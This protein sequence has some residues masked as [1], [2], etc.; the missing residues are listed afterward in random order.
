[1]TGSENESSAAGLEY[2]EAQRDLVQTRAKWAARL[3]KIFGGARPVRS[4]VDRP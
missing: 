3:H 4:S 2:R 1:M